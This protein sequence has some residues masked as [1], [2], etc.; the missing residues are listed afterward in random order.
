MKFLFKYEDAAYTFDDEKMS[1][2]EARFVRTVTGYT[3]AEFFEQARKLDPDAIM[4]ILV[5]AK[6]RAGEEAKM[7]DFDLDDENGYIKLIQSLDVAE[8]QK[9]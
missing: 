1:L 7:E 9:E 8:S 4:A 2:G 6:R 3:G 5:M